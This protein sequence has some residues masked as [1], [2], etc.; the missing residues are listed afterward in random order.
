[1]Y[2]SRITRRKS[3][4]EGVYQNMTEFQK[5]ETSVKGRFDRFCNET[6]FTALAKIHNAPT[7]FKRLAW[8]L[9]VCGMLGWLGVQCYW[10]L[11]KYFSYPIEVKFDII[12]RSKMEFPSVTICNINPL[13]HKK[14]Y[15]GAFENVTEYFNHKASEQELMYDKAKEDMQSKL[16][17]D[18][19]SGK[20][21]FMSCNNIFCK[22]IYRLLVIF[23]LVIVCLYILFYRDTPDMTLSSGTPDLVV[24]S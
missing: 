17:G 1:M 22:K 4:K 12:S 5:T 11:D 7:L 14:L 20:C 24:S 23:C 8:L 2:H 13:R 18:L 9:I 16:L 19:S 21:R 15:M 10:L 6:S 3:I